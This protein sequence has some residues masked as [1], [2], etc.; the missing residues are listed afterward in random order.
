MS[1]QANKKLTGNDN[2]VDS[3]ADDKKVAPEAPSI[4]P[5]AIE[6][7]DNHS[8]R[9]PVITQANYSSTNNTKQEDESNIIR[10]KLTGYVGFANLPQQW[11]KKSTKKG[12][13]MNLMVVGESGLG[14]STLVNTLF[15]M[16]LYD[17]KE[18]KDPAAEIPKTVDITTVSADLEE[19]NVKLHLTV[20]DTPG[21]GDFVNNSD[22]WKPI[23]DDIDQRFDS[24]LEMENKVNRTKFE[25]NRV[26]ACVYFIQ[27][28]GHSLKPLDI[29]VMKKLHKKVNLVPVI[30]KADTLTEQELQDFK[31]RILEDIKYQGIEIFEPP[32]YENDDDETIAE[33]EGIMSKVP[34]AIVG[35]TDLVEKT[36]GKQVKQVRGRQYPWG[37]IEVDNPDHCDFVKLR[38]L[39]IKNHLEELRE[40]TAKVLYEN[41]RTEKL[42]ALGIQQDF[43]VFREV[44]PGTRQEEDRAVH[45]ARLAKMEKD[46]KSVFQ[47]KVAEKEQKLKRSEAELFARHKEMKE[48]LEKE[49][50]TLEAKKLKLEQGRMADEKKT[51]KGF[52][53]R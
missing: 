25:D 31:Y 23:V 40:R 1:L 29:Q 2:K 34:F 17:A 8:L 43:S 51:R 18:P 14:K 6:P 26:H 33:N 44:R 11:H 16:G 46:M 28:T 48:Q 41:Y 37:I 30:A 13:N 38:Q 9:S 53:L 27:P 35:S 4:A 19:G 42:S 10:R 50:A 24:Y 15:N 39:L 7:M 20:I 49:K 32:R 45:E 52:S 3:S 47:T 21:F 12:F 36:D 22:S 5:I